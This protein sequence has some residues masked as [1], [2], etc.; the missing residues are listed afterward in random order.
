MRSAVYHLVGLLLIA[1]ACSAVDS[2]V[3]RSAG[4]VFGTPERKY[5]LGPYS[6]STVVPAP[7]LQ[8]LDKYKEELARVDAA[9]AFKRWVTIFDEDANGTDW[10]PSSPSTA[11]FS[12]TAE[13]LY[14]GAPT[15]YTLNANT[16]F[17]TLLDETLNDQT[18]LFAAV[19]TAMNED[20]E[21][22]SIRSVEELRAFIHRNFKQRQSIVYMLSNVVGVASNSRR[23]YERWIYNHWEPDLVGLPYTVFAAGELISAKETDVSETAFVGP[24]FLQGLVGN[25]S[26]A[27]CDGSRR[28]TTMQLMVA[29]DSRMLAFAAVHMPELMRFGLRFRHL[30]DHDGISA[31][32][33]VAPFERERLVYFT[34]PSFVSDLLEKWSRAMHSRSLYH[35]AEKNTQFVNDLKSDIEAAFGLLDQLAIEGVKSDPEAPKYKSRLWE[36]PA[37]LD[38]P[39]FT[40]P[41]SAY[42]YW[43]REI[44]LQLL[45]TYWPWSTTPSFPSVFPETAAIMDMLRDK[46][47]R[48]NASGARHIDYIMQDDW[49]EQLH[50]TARMAQANRLSPDDVTS[51]LPLGAFV[52]HYVRFV[53]DRFVE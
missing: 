3:S 11:P 31:H 9:S 38:W 43:L 37:E 46:L 50:Y 47:E 4:A 34:P 13:T 32:M 44:A 53:Q 1:S 15:Q 36:I 14:S 8:K 21:D 16:S 22:P 23:L 29:Y 12:V 25:Q 18:E 30:A 40:T 19:L 39:E 28:G 24:A 5:P 20:I 10:L 26:Q 49:Y 6:T 51:T 27:D 2:R 42:R 17:E 45:Q 41:Q 33:L 48:R 52:Y 7:I 35:F